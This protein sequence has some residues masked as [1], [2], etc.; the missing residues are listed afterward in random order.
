MNFAQRLIKDSTDSAKRKLYEKQSEH[1]WHNC[2]TRQDT[3]WRFQCPSTKFN[4]VWKKWGIYFGVPKHQCYSKNNYCQ[5]GCP[6]S[7]SEISLSVPK[8]ECIPPKICQY[9]CPQS[10]WMWSANRFIRG[11]IGTSINNNFKAFKRAVLRKFV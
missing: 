6:L 4:Y 9:A 11:P 7:W 1:S 2:N 10:K 5:Y 3:C 8:H